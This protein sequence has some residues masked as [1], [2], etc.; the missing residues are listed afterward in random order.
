VQTPASAGCA[1]VELV[2]VKRLAND[3]IS[4]QFPLRCSKNHSRRSGSRRNQKIFARGG[5][6]RTRGIGS[7]WPNWSESH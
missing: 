3:A 6:D 5:I 7:F 4:L 1:H 2:S